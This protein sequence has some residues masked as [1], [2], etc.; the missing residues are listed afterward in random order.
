M[1]EQCGIC[2]CQLHRTKG[3]YARPTVEGRSHATRHHYVAERFF[4]RSANRLGTKTEN[5]F[6]SCPWGHEGESVIF[7]YECHEELIHNPVLL[8]EDVSRFAE[9]V[10]QRGLAE[11]LKTD[12]R[13]PIAGRVALFHEVIAS[14]LASLLK[15]SSA[16]N[17]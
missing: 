14:G 9:L 4:G 8:P 16:S 11:E 10:K 6:L 12:N 5:M 17:G 15:K 7:C 2:G 1:T 13:E 3:T